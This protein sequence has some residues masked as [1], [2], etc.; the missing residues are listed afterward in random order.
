MIID[1]NNNTVAHLGA[2][3]RAGVTSIGRYIAAGLEHEQ[4]VIKPSEA[5]AIADAGLRLFLIYESTAK[6]SLEGSE[7]GQYDGVF[8]LG[9]AKSVG[10]Q[11]GDAIYA[12]VD[13]DASPSELFDVLNYFSAFK[14]ALGGYF[15]L[16]AYASG[17]VCDELYSRGIIK[18]RW[19]TMSL[20]FR[21]SRDSARAGRYELVQQVDRKIAGLDVDPDRTHDPL[22]DFGDFVPFAMSVVESDAFV[23]PSNVVVPV[24]APSDTSSTWNVHPIRWLT[25]FFK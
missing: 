11:K 5:K 19:L 25:S 14:D 9:W 4:K 15:E 3:K 10:A 20:G 22:R 6:R 13:F 24:I 8:A 2:F 18:Y 16:G 7:A 21:G 1:S 23:P 17:Y 12:T